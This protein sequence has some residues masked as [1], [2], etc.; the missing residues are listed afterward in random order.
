M[1]QR[2]RSTE[3]RDLR[4]PV[5]LGRGAGGHDL[6]IVEL[7]GNEPRR[8]RAGAAAEVVAQRAFLAIGQV[9]K[10]RAGAFDHAL[11]AAGG[12][13]DRVALA[14]ERSAVQGAES[15][16]C[17]DDAVGAGPGAVANVVTP[18]GHGCPF[19]AGCGFAARGNRSRLRGCVSS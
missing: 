13:D 16:A 14:G 9:G 4:R 1:A 7:V 18:H 11:L 2:M 6:E 5:R 19:L 17:L 3:A 10:A 12:T 15:A 8:R